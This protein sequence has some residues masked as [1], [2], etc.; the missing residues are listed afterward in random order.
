MNEEAK[1][2]ATEQMK[3]ILSKAPTRREL[4]WGELKNGI[5]PRWVAQKYGLDP[6]KVMKAKADLMAK[7]ATKVV[8]DKR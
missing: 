5:D 3:R 4:A 2:L 8:G 6:E 7:E 1:Q